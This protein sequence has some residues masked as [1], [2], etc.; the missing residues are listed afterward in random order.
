MYALSDPGTI[1]HLL[2]SSS[3]FT[4]CGFRVQRLDDSVPHKRAELHFVTEV[5]SSRSLCKHCEQMQQRRKGMSDTADGMFL[6]NK[7]E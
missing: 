6:T 2:Y 5:P 1:Y 4:L 3:N 7:S